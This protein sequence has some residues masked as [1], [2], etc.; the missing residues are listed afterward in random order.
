M[1]PFCKLNVIHHVVQL[2]INY[3]NQLVIPY[4]SN[5]IT[6]SSCWFNFIVIIV[7]FWRTVVAVDI[8]TGW[9]VEL[10]MLTFSP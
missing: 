6:Y 2:K 7:E 5:E 4:S 3:Y 10:V 1:K 8:S 9:N